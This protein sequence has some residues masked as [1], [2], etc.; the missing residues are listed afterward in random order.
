MEIKES[1]GCVAIVC[2]SKSKYPLLSFVLHMTGAIAHGNTVV[3]IPDETCPVLALDL[4]EV[5][6]TSD[7]PDGVCNILTGGRYHLSKYIVEHQQVSAVWYLNETNQLQGDE[8][9]MQQFIRFT[10]SHS[11]KN[12]WLVNIPLP[13]IQNCLAVDKAYLYEIQKHSNQF[14]YVHIP[15]GVIF[16]N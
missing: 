12:A 16:A 6:E 1:L 8:L 5:L 9:A 10:S 13:V 11:L 2:D 15:M 7:M 14:K 4:Y 3:I